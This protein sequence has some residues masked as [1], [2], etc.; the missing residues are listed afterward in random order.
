[1]QYDAG[2]VNKRA[3]LCHGTVHA[4]EGVAFVQCFDVSL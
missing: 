2:E 3:W 4:L 1:M